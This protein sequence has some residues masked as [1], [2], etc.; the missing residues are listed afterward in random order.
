M[1]I[2]PST[3]PQHGSFKASQSIAPVTPMLFIRILIPIV[4]AV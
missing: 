1:L 2:S 4:I 3:T